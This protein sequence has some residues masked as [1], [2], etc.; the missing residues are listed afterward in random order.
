MFW[1]SGE[2]PPAGLAPTDP[3]AWSCRSVDR[4]RRSRRDRSVAESRATWTALAT[5]AAGEP[6]AVFVDQKNVVLARPERGTRFRTASEI[7]RSRPTLR[8]G[9]AVHA[10]PPCSAGPRRSRFCRISLVPVRRTGRP[11][12]RIQQIRVRPTPAG[13]P[14]SGTADGLVSNRWRQRPAR[15]QSKPIPTPPWHV[16]AVPKR[17][18]AMRREATRQSTPLLVQQVCLE[19]R[20]WASEGAAAMRSIPAAWERPS[21]T[22]WGRS[23]LLQPRPSRRRH[24]RQF[25]R[26]RRRRQSAFR[27]P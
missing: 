21:G 4:F 12:Q 2:I 5:A 11:E 14:S 3:A 26:N 15:T 18:V 27:P 10:C 24:G 13:E 1:R 7:C 16:L 19:Y 9:Y 17:R 8:A 6:P 20:A 25:G 22:A 23:R